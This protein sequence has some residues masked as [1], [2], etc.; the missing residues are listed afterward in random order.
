MVIVEI[1]LTQG[2]INPNQLRKLVQEVTE[3][4]PLPPEGV[5]ISGRMPVW[6]FSALTAAL[7]SAGTKAV[8]T[9]D[10]RLQAGVVV[11]PLERAGELI[12]VTGDEEKVEVEF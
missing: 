10:P 6:A 12:P 2:I 3:K 4:L 1:V 9:Y 7:V 5:I 11:H 8:A